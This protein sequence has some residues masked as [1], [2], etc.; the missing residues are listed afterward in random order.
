MP[1]NISNFYIVKEVVDMGGIDAL[2]FVD[3]FKGN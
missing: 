2:Q 3:D 1:E